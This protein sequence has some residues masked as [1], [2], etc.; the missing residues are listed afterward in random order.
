M[1][2][3]DF[4]RKEQAAVPVP[5][6]AVYH[7]GDSRELTE[8]G[9]GSNRYA[10]LMAREVD[11]PAAGTFAQVG[12]AEARNAMRSTMMGGYEVPVGHEFH[13]RQLVR[14]ITRNGD[15]AAAEMVARGWAT[16]SSDPSYEQVQASR[17]AAMDFNSGMPLMD[18]NRFFKDKYNQ[19]RLVEEMHKAQRNPGDRSTTAWQE[20]GIGLNRG[21]HQVAG[22]LG[23]GLQSY[24]GEV[25]GSEDTVNRGKNFSRSM[26]EYNRVRAAPAVSSW[27]DVELGS[28]M[29]K[30]LAGKAGE[31][32]AQ[33]VPYAVA[34][35]V[36]GVGEAA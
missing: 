17:A 14:G 1:A 25:V 26:E 15:D 33:M 5:E 30:Y 18:G 20:L 32:G 6:D 2:L 8:G 36:R 29:G 3:F 4:F 11:N 12:G 27:D 19:A 23:G 24:I 7:D 13:G 10:G 21:A 34:S 22:M 16:P 35:M 28:N 9:M 31:V